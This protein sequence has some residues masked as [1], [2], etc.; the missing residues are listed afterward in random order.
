MIVPQGAPGLTAQGTLREL[1]K[2]PQILDR[3]PLLNRSDEVCVRL[4]ASAAD[5]L[6]DQLGPRLRQLELIDPELIAK[7]AAVSNTAAKD[8]TCSTRA[9]SA[10]GNTVN[11]I[12]PSLL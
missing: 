6:A 2:H 10:P 3:R 9:G 4:A 7:A 1:L 8:T 12:A 5:N 11:R